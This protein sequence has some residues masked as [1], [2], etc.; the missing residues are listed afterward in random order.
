[1]DHDTQRITLLKALLD[2]NPRYRHLEI[3]MGIVQNKNN[4][5]VH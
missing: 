3:P 1:M 2:D 4:L 5:S